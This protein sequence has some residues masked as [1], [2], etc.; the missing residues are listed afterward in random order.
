LSPVADDDELVGSSSAMREVQK[1][2]GLLADSD[3]QS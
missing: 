3:S 1:I 2:I